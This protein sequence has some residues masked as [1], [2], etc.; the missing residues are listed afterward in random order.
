M[1]IQTLVLLLLLPL[2]VWR[3]YSRLQAMM[4]RQQSR[5]WLHLIIIVGCAAL[6]GVFAAHASDEPLALA[7]LAGATVLGAVLGQRALKQ[8][9]FEKT[10]E[11]LFTTPNRR[12]AMAIAM[13]F[14]ARLLYRAFELYAAMGTPAQA[15]LANFAGSPI[16]AIASGLLSGYFGAYHAGLLR[17]HRA[18]R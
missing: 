16:S 9:R 6:V 4:G 15:D 10:Q 2:L 17:W 8:T 13:L 5:V 14:V 11:G 1:N 7:C 3:I 18:R 12:I